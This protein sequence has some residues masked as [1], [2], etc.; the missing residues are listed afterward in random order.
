MTGKRLLL[1]PGLVAVVLIGLLP[2]ASMFWASD[3]AQRHGCDLNE[4]NIQ[5]CIVNGEDWGE[6]LY[7]AFVS[8]WFA[9]LTLPVAAAALLAMLVLAVI[10]LIR[11]VKG[12]RKV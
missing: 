1:Y 11:Y 4:G 7:S 5:P 10:D 3:F 12:V 8:G 6:T 2:V 9:L